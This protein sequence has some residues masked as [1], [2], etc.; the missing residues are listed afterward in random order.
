MALIDI[1]DTGEGPPPRSTQGCL[2]GGIFCGMEVGWHMS[3]YV[4]FEEC[5]SKTAGFMIFLFSG[6]EGALEPPLMQLGG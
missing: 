5:S 3:L 1:F 2:R 4:G 6:G